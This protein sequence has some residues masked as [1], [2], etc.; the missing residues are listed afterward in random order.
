MLHKEYRTLEIR[1]VRRYTEISIVVVSPTFPNVMANAISTIKMFT[2]TNK[3]M[4]L[5]YSR[6]YAWHMIS[7]NTVI[8]RVIHLETFRYDKIAN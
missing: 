8:S 2:S 1:F 3:I 4:Y 7:C 6:H 5:L